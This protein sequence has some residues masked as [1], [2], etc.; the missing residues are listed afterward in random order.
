MNIFLIEDDILWQ[1]ELLMLLEKIGFVDV[2]VCNTVQETYANLKN[3]VPNI[4]LADILL[5]NETIFNIFSLDE[6]F[7]QLPFIFITAEKNIELFNESKI[8]PNSLFLVKPFHELSLLAAIESLTQHQPKTNTLETTH[9]I[10]VRGIYKEKICIPVSKVVFIK[11]E[12]A[13]CK[14]KTP[15]HNFVTKGS[16]KNIAEKLGSDIL[17]INK[18]YAVNKTYIKKINLTEMTILTDFGTLPIGRVYKKSV[19]DYLNEIRII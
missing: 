13:Y 2:T 15:N 5:E 11:S 17:Q 4:I 18:A 14:I 19:A 9:A 10:T 1:T 16:I 6:S 12:L 7:K 8:I 3:N